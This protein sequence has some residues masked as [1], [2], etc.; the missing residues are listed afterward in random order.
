MGM[1]T[2]EFEKPAG[3]EKHLPPGQGGQV[4]FDRKGHFNTVRVKP[5]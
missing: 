2:D 1:Y 5:P 4:K 3:D